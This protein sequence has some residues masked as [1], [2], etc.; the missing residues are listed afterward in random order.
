VA[1][2]ASQTAHLTPGASMRQISPM[3]ALDAATRARVWQE[4]VDAVEAAATSDELSMFAELDAAD[5][6]A[7][8]ERLDFEVPM[9]AV[10]AVRFAVEGLSRYAVNIRSPRY[11][12]LF[13][14]APAAMG[15]VAEALAAAFN[16][17]LAAWVASPFA[18][19]AE[20]YVIRALGAR[21]G[22][23]ADSVDGT[24]TSG[25]AEANHTAVLTAL[26]RSFPAFAERGL[27]GLPAQPVF[28]L[29]DEAHPSL[30]KAARATGLG[31]EGL[32]RVP[33]DARLRVDLDLLRTA[34]ARDRSDGFAPFMVVATAGTT[35]AG[36]ID[37]IS[38]VADI[39]AAENLWL[40]VDAAWGGAAALLP[41]L[42]P[43]LAGIARADSITFDPHKLLSVP[44]GAGLYLTRHAGLL[45]TTFQ[46]STSYVPGTAELVDPYTH[47]LQWSRRFIGLKVLLALAVAGWDGYA[48]VLR[49]Q[50]EMAEL[51]R[52]R[53][54]ET[55]WQLVN[56]TPLPLV[57]FV[58]TAGADPDA[59]VDAVNASRDARIFTATLPPGRRVIR[60]AIT[61]FR[62]GPRDIDTLIE[63]LDRA[64]RRLQHVA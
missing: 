63:A 8:V 26:T 45:D 31:E 10:D 5:V 41:E 35:S 58:D 32:R 60:A 43:A 24:F 56:D 30:L 2:P 14:P 20:G 36:V 55:D 19:E 11:F 37:P 61:N 12:G 27:R 57:C 46:V 47:S 62:T 42:R 34:I 64:R 16:P 21:F 38:A 59:T 7:F 13:D 50:L 23:R 29:S 9:D 49:H 48:T 1:E 18:I 54:E 25:G 22:L 40:H 6:R 28:Y 53:L 39:A 51:L 33:V 44:I 3:L 15:V 17:Q 4:L 52:R